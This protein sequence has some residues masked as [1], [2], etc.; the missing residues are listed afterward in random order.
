MCRVSLFIIEYDATRI[1]IYYVTL[2]IYRRD[3]EINV[4]GKLKVTGIYRNYENMCKKSSNK[5]A[6]ADIANC[7]RS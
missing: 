2:Y 5:D 4:P 3:V 6:T 7:D 1:Y